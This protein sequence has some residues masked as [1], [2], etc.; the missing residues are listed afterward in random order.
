MK[1]KHILALIIL[2]CSSATAQMYSSFNPGQIW[3]D[4]NGVHINA[5]GGGVLYNDGVYY[6]FG[7]HKIEG[8]KG[9]RAYVGVHCYSS[10]DLYNWS[11][12]GIA[13]SVIKDAPK[14]PLAAGCILERPKVIYNK[15]TNKF[16]MWFHHELIDK[17]YSAALSGIAISDK[18]TG[19]YTYI[20]SIR[21]NKG[22]WPINV[23]DVHKQPV[24]Q[25][26]MET[27]YYG[28]SLPQHPDVLNTLGKGYITGQMARDMTLFVDD[29]DKAYHLYASEYNSTL[30]IAELTDDYTAHTGKFARA[31]VARWMEAPT[32][33]KYN[34]KYYFI[35]SGCTGWNPNTARCAIADSIWGPW[36]ELGNS[37]KGPNADLTFKGQSTYVLPVYGK[38]CAFIFMADRW[39]PENAIDGRYLWLPIKFT[40]NSDNH[41]RIEINWHDKWDLTIF[42]H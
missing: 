34:G 20:H 1:I 21:P 29:D 25:E 10:K 22:K 14:H 26:V 37:C 30:H 13:L 28:G 33:F 12:E 23:M 4:N 39:N 27:Y 36:M 41:E 16:V 35:G 15:K 32:I 2:F 17:G 24:K 9:N 7:E 8:E 6:W 5:H 40:R 19:P 38:Q 18:A 42:D 3:K 31:F 11:D